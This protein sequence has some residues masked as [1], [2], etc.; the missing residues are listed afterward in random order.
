MKQSTAATRLLRLINSQAQQQ[1]DALPDWLQRGVV[2]E[3]GALL[4]GQLRFAAGMWRQNEM[5]TLPD[6]LGV[7]SSALGHSHEIP[8]PELLRPL[9][10][11]D[12]VVV[13]LYLDGS[14]PVVLCRDVGT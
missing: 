13:G 10:A 1:L 14:E 4:V 8:R 12:L 3:D 11:G 2:Q 5:Y 6:P 7:S 9:E